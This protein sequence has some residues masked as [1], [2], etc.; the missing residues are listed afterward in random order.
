MNNWVE[1]ICDIP[2]SKLDAVKD[3]MLTCGQEFIDWDI[4]RYAV[5]GRYYVKSRYPESM[6]E[7][8]WKNGIQFNQISPSTY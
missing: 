3:A 5:H 2:F 4:S 6:K 1:V 7:A 8:L